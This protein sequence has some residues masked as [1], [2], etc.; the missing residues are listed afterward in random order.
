MKSIIVISNNR[1]STISIMNII[2]VI[3]SYIALTRN[4][5]ETVLT[6][7]VVSFLSLLRL[8]NAE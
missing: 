4:I 8:N 3:V 2:I 5:P 6:I 7:F 1:G